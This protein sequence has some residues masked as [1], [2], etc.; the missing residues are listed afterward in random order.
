MSPASSLCL[1][2]S[3]SSH[4]LPHRLFFSFRLFDFQKQKDATEERLKN[5]ENKKSGGKDNT[6]KTNEMLLRAI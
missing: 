4:R 5:K 6:K 2:S 1:S 3:S